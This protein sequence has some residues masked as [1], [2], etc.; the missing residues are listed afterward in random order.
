[1]LDRAEAAV[2]NRP[3]HVGLTHA[4]APAEAED[5]L[6]QIKDRLT[7]RDTFITDLALSLAVHFGPGT[8]GFATYPAE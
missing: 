6:A 2:G 1:M 8:V 3:V 4:L 7:C 5:L